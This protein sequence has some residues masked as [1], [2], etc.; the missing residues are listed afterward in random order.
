MCICALFNAASSCMRKVLG[1]L[2]CIICSG[3]ILVIVGI[4]LLATPNDRADRVSRYN[5][6]V[7]SFNSTGIS[8]GSGWANGGQIGGA[9]V[10]AVTESVPME[11]GQSGVDTTGTSVYVRNTQSPHSSVSSSQ[12]YAVNNVATFTR[13]LT[14][15]RSFTTSISCPDSGSTCSSTTQSN[16]CSNL[17]GGTYT[18]SSCSSGSSCGSCSYSTFLTTY[19]AVASRTSATANSWI[20]ATSLQSCFYPFGTSSQRYA[21]S[22]SSIE[23]RLMDSKDPFIA[24]ERETKGSADFGIT[25]EQQRTTGIVLLVIGLVII[26][27]M[28]IVIFVVIRLIMAAAGGNDA[29]N[30]AAAGGGN[31]MPAQQMQSYPQQT[32]GPGYGAQPQQGGYGAPPPAGG[33]GAPPPA[34]GYGSPPPAGGY[35]QQPVVQGYP[36]QQQAYPQ[37][38]AGYPPAQPGYNAQPAGY[39]PQPGYAAQPG[40]APQ[41]GYG[42]QPGYAGQPG[43]MY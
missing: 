20:E 35:A 12:V 37:Q 32:Q 5:Q 34:G 16:K 41:P 3:P 17:Y 30:A 1:L 18:G 6:A 28:A 14:K 7:A 11:A 19:C 25:A 42:A 36:V 29:N 24:L 13:T 26:G 27:I 43:K 9:A 21:S 15:T 22:S 40:Y 33:Y 31:A 23:M 4:V 8:G 2:C 38:A 39:A 10:T